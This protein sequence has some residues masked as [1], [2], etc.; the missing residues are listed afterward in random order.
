MPHQFCEFQAPTLI[1]IHLLSS[2]LWAFVCP[3]GCTG[4]RMVHW[5]LCDCMCI[6]VTQDKR[7]RLYLRELLRWMVLSF[8]K[9]GEFVWCKGEQEVVSC[10]NER[11]GTNASKDW[12]RFV[13]MYPWNALEHWN[14]NF[15]ISDCRNSIL[16]IYHLVGFIT[17]QNQTEMFFFFLFFCY[18]GYISL[19][20]AW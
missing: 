1:I 2:V 4:L 8:R 18:K 20:I 3:N 14:R 13:I 16:H 17:C 12:G 19:E 9:C 11:A 6:F 7:R 10:V 5:Y 15:S